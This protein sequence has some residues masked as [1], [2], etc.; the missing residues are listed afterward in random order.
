MKIG[1][2]RVSTADQ[3]LDAQ[4]DALKAAG[5]ERIFEEHA[6]GARDDRPQLRAALDALRKGDALVIYKLDRLGRS[7]RSLIDFGMDL[8]RR[9]I[10][11]ISI[12][13]SIDTST[14]MGRFTY[15]LLGAIAEME[16]GLIRERTN[17][18]LASA[19]AR[20]RLGGRP[21]KMTAKDIDLAK[22]MV[23]EGTLTFD[24]IA[25]RFNVS[26]STIYRAC[27]LLPPPRA[28]QE[29]T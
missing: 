6:S 10:D 29:Q 8:E 26:R 14:V 2:A 23:D 5:C 22:R 20:G 11:L 13:D 17:S 15:H 1:Y 7:L 16:R 28:A 19:R 25:E 18:G 3:N 4:R 27:G 9:G 21:A 24:Q 12:N